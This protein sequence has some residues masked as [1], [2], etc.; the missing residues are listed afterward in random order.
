MPVLPTARV[1]ARPQHMRANR[2]TQ[3]A[4][5]TQQAAPRVRL[6]GSS[7]QAC[8]ESGA[9]LE[10]G[11]STHDRGVRRTSPSSVEYWL[12]EECVCVGGARVA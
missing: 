4:R 11:R 1:G 7:Q 9:I 10:D 2:H 8:Q 12:T 6:Q 5:S 3:Q